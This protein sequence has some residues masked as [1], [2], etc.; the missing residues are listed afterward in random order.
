MNYTVKPLVCDYGLYD[1]TNNLIFILNNRRNALL[2]KDILDLDNNYKNEM[3]CSR[4]YGP[5]EMND[6]MKHY[7]NNL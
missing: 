2:I 4:S 6:F 5:K 3:N 7:M 1:D